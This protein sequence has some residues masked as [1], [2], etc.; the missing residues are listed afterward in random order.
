MERTKCR[1]NNDHDPKYA[2][3]SV[4]HG[5]GSTVVSWSG[6]HLVDSLIVIDTGNHD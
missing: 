5:G 1:A 2:S 6:P 4:K 3:L